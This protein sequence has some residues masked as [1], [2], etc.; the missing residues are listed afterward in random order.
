MA[1]DALDHYVARTSAVNDIDYVDFVGPG[2]TR[3][4]ILG[5]RV[6]SLGSNDIK[7]KYMFMFPL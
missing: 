4:R 7:C 3:G 5:T 1:A 6:I 2:P